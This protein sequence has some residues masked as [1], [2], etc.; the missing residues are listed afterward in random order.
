MPA[1]EHGRDAWFAAN[2]ANWESRVPVHLRSATYPVEEFVAGKLALD[3]YDFT[4]LGN[5]EG[6][7]LLHLQCHLGLETLSWARLGA[8]VTGLD[9]SPA[10]LRAARDLAA[11]AS[12]SAEFVEA[13]VLDAPQALAG[14]RFDVVYASTGT[15]VWVPSAHEWMAVASAC[16][17]RG[18]RLFLRDAHPALQAADDESPPGVLSIS[19]SYFEEAQPLRFVRS[20]SYVPDADGQPLAQ[21]VTYQ[22]NHS[23]GEVVGAALAA[24]LRI[25]HFEEL[26]WC[27]W[28]AL[29]WLER[30]TDRRW[31]APVGMPRLPLS[32]ALVAVKP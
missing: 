14:R 27:E 4:V 22:W 16:L 10:A 29:P 28:R 11:R 20:D 12:L 2:R 9:F 15:L 24:G 7:E 30:G 3:P 25:E 31:R 21:P 8:R 6:Q 13:N 1:S 18:G 26:D 32:F 23:L 17:R 5:V 19:W